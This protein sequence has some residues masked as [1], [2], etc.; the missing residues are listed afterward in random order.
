MS[1]TIKIHK[2]SGERARMNHDSTDE[3]N[4]QE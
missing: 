4:K 1:L 3:Q 2:Q